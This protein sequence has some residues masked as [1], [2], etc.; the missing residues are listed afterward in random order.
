M[1]DAESRNFKDLAQSA[2]I[3]EVMGDSGNSYVIFFMGDGSVCA[4]Q[5]KPTQTRAGAQLIFS[6]TKKCLLD[7]LKAFGVDTPREQ[8]TYRIG[9]ELRAVL[10]G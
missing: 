5:I 2:T 1:A 10:E 3:Y 6:E 7:C 4:A 9:H 8:T